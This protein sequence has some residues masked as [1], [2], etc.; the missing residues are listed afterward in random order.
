[1]PIE[2]PEFTMAK[3]AFSL[4]AKK[5]A[6]ANPVELHDPFCVLDALTDSPKM[7]NSSV[8]PWFTEIVVLPLLV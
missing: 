6:L 3:E 5:S 2:T 7:L 8:V 4:P 1:V